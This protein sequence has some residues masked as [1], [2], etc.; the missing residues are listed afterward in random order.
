MSCLLIKSAGSPPSLM[1][2]GH[3]NCR[4]N[5]GLLRVWR[6]RQYFLAVFRAHRVATICSER[7]VPPGFHRCIPLSPPSSPAHWGPS[8]LAWSWGAGAWL[9]FK[10]PIPHC[11]QVL[12]SCPLRIL[13]DFSNPKPRHLWKVTQAPFHHLFSAQSTLP[14]PNWPCISFLVN[15]AFTTTSPKN[16][17]TCSINLRVLHSPSAGSWLK[18]DLVVLL[19][20]S[21]AINTPCFSWKWVSHCCYWIPASAGSAQGSPCAVCVLQKQFFAPRNAV[22]QRMGW[23][24]HHHRHLRSSSYAAVPRASQHGSHRSLK[25]FSLKQ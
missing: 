6:W 8:V 17:L 19:L 3:E 21:G 5:R 23:C 22:G 16:T 9:H 14:Y 18:M 11:F 20:I 7:L 2:P 25:S 24:E 1:T 4:D 13:M 12:T 10:M 15:A